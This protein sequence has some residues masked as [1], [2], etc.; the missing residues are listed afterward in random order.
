MIPLGMTTNSLPLSAAGGCWQHWGPREGPTVC[1]QCQSGS[2]TPLLSPCCFV[3]KVLHQEL[4]HFLFSWLAAYAF[5]W[6]HYYYFHQ[7]P[8]LL[9]HSL[10]IQA[11]AGPWWGFQKSPS[12]SGGLCNSCRQRFRTP[13]LLLAPL[14][15]PGLRSPITADTPPRWIL[16]RQRNQISYCQHPLDQWKC[17]RFP[18]KHLHLLYWLRQSLRLCITTKFGRF[19]KRWEYQATL[20][21]S[22]EICMQVK[23]Q[24]LELDM[25]QQTGSK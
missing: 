6:L 5:L 17:K 19:F 12:L 16:K 21:A 4:W 13:R 18:E 20:L 10:C 23:K 8:H 22:W 14:R 7:L 9:S 24:K 2:Q 11:A 15:D 3:C 1:G 25:E